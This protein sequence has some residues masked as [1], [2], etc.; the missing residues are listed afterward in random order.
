MAP[1]RGS[2][3]ESGRLCSCVSGLLQ[4]A[5]GVRSGCE[6]SAGF[7]ESAFMDA[8]PEPAAETSRPVAVITGAAVRIGRALALDLAASGWRVVV[9]FGRSREQAEITVEEIREGAG[10][11]ICVAADLL[12]PHSAA[13][14]VFAAAEQH[15]GPVSLLINNAAIFE[16]GPLGSTDSDTWDRLFTINLKAP[17]VLSERFVQ[18]LGETGS[19][20]IIN[21]AD[22]RGLKLDPSRLA[23]SLSKQGLVALTRTLAATL[24]PRVRVNAVAPGP[25]LPPPDSSP[26][27]LVRAAAESPLGRSGGPEDV[28]AAVDYLL[29]A[30]LVTGEVLA[31]AGGAQLSREPFAE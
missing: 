5:V 2:D 14:K 1:R 9:H 7:V 3:T 29:Q 31:V 12:E 28:V 19:G 11:A 15:F 30:E 20:Q 25:I 10:E 21:L 6:M 8:R 23:Y 26:D 27:L 24:A 17:C 16:G 13:E 18:G 4:E 22:W